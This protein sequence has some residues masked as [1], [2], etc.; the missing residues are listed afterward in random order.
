[1]VEENEHEVD[2]YEDSDELLDDDELDPTEAA[3]M[4]G[5]E[6][7][8][9]SEKKEIEEEPDKDDRFDDEDEETESEKESEEE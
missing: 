5:Y 8:G 1:M 6:E 7:A 3:F 9:D 2:A 4:K